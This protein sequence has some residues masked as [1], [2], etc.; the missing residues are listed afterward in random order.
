ME[1]LMEVY[2]RF[3]MVFSFLLSPTPSFISA[4]ERICLAPK[5]IWSN[6]I[7]GKERLH[8]KLSLN[9]FLLINYKKSMTNCIHMI[10]EGIHVNAHDMYMYF[11]LTTQILLNCPSR[12]A[13]WS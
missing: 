11:I 9:Q 8:S 12:Q 6:M 1:A 4:Y 10:F 13:R 7:L 3:A 5:L 2:G